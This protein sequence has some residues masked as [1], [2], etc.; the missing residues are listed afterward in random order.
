MALKRNAQ[1]DRARLNAYFAALPPDT[2]RT[3]KRMRDAIRAAAPRAVDAVSYGIPAVRLDGKLVVWYAA[4]KEH[5][6]IYPVGAAVRR[7]H[8]ADLKGFETSK[9][10]VRFP[11]AKPLPTALVK[12][13]VKSMV[14]AAAAKR[15]R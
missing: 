7:A 2:R 5:C 11:L 4:W 15:K 12:R 6:S 9:G 10:T 14:A 3:L 1:P 8:A 13:L